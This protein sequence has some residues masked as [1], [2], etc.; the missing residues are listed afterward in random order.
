MDTTVAGGSSERIRVLVEGALCVALSV[1][2]SYL[3]ILPMPQ[4]GSITLEM[5]PLLFFSYRRGVKW[6]LAA[7]AMSGFLQLLLGGYVVHPIQGVLDYPAAFACMGVAGIA[8]HH[9]LLGTAASC[10]LRLLCHV[11][12]GAIFFASYAPEGQNPWLYSLVYNATYMIPSMI[13]SFA[14]AW[15]LWSRLASMAGRRGSGGKAG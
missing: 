7:G 9:F 11:L 15:L 6:G 3:K 10:A 12:S 2:L 8:G 14:A 1:V 4:G 13:I 5:S